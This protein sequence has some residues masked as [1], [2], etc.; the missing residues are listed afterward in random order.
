MA[1]SAIGTLSWVRESGGRLR[2]GEKLRFQTQVMLATVSS[3]LPAGGDPL[4][5]DLA[6]IHIPD[7]TDVT[8]SIEMM[9]D[10]LPHWLRNHCLRVYLW[11]SILAQ[12]D[13]L[14]FDEE[15]LFVSCAVHDLGAADTHRGKHGDV[16]CFAVE[17]AIAGD[18]LARTLEW[19]P[20]RRDRLFEAVTLHIN[21]AVPVEQ[22]AEAHLLAGGAALDVIGSRATEID[23]S[24]RAA[25]IEKHPRLGFK[26][27][28]SGRMAEEARARPHSR[29]RAVT[30]LGYPMMIRN[31]P[32]DD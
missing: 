32:F 20:Q 27:Q 17:G 22:G 23:V 10:E 19:S 7:S 15:L 2:L 8:R 6:A 18:E 13:E 21:P 30:Q 28:F 9:D 3:L 25:I 11:G 29:T 14:R 4:R 12:R 24:T 1:V 26:A 16:G 31:A 5:V